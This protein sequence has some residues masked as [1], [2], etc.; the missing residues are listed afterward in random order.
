M[1]VNEVDDKGEIGD[2]PIIKEL[3]DRTPTRLGART[4]LKQDGAVIRQ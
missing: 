3:D 1:W 4:A 2:D